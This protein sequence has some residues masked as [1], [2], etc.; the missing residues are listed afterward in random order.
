MAKM[1]IATMRIRSSAAE[2]IA[3]G[4]GEKDGGGDRAR[5][6]DQRDGERKDR[7]VADVVGLRDLGALLLPVLTPLEDHLEGDV[8]E[9]H[10]AGDA[11]GGMVMPKTERMQEPGDREEDEDRRTR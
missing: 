6:G 9:Q 3:V 4:A 10:A 8:E 2:D 5:P 11:E 7:D 1:L